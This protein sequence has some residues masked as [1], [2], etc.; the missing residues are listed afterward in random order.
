MRYL[1]TGGAGFIGSH[2]TT[3]LVE[4]GH[5]VRVLDNYAT[6][7]PENLEHIAGAFDLHVGDVRDLDALRRATAGVDYVIHL[8]ALPSVPRSVKDP[9]ATNEVNVSGTL[10][11]LIAA[12]DAGVRRLVMASSSSVYGANREL[13]KNERMLP[14][15]M[16][17]Y[18][19]SKLA[20]ERYCLA[21]TESYGLE[22]CAL[23]YFNVFGPRQNPHSQYSAVVPVFVRCALSGLPLPVDGDG[24]QT[25]DFTYVENVVDGTL[26]ACE[27]PGASGAVLNLACGESHSVNDLVRAV[28][29][30]CGRPLT[31]EHRAERVADVKHSVADISEAERVLGYRPRIGFAEGIASVVRAFESALDETRSD[32]AGHAPPERGGI[33]S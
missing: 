29:A 17:P 27:A 30:A 31:V 33:P 9:L 8:A 7:R 19:V 21:F 26:A 25:R 3:R 18:A 1:V 15:P 12:R 32:D 2:I 5:D 24:E 28:E 23:R 6:G 10:N 20:A 22:T 11:V 4:M 13:P 14:L 16:S